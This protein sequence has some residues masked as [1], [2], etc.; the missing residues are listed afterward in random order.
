[1]KQTEYERL[2]KDKAWIKKLI[3]AGVFIQ[4]NKLHAVFD[5][6]NEVS[7]KQ[8][9]LMAV[10]K[11][12]DEA[13][14]LSTL[15]GAMGC[16]RQNVKKLALNLEK[17]GYITLTKSEQDARSLCMGLTDKGREYSEYMASVGAEV[18]DAV[19]SEFT[20]EEI[21]QYYKLSV[22][23]MHGID[24]LEIYFQ[25]KIQEENNEDSSCVQKQK[26]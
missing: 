16:S 20:E 21:E 10:S 11:A 3:F 8:W 7:S 22:K 9:L 19:F 23:L 5:R 13:P 24:H 15:A 4:E 2:G 25:K 17:S 12:F 14:D 18:H 6:Y 26:K 1:M